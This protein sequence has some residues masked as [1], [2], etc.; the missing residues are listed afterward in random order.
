VIAWAAAILLAAR[1]GGAPPGSSLSPSPPTSALV[2]AE[3]RAEANRRPASFCSLDVC[4]P[5]LAIPG[6][7]AKVG[8]HAGRT[9]LA[10]A[11]LAS[12]DAEPISGVARSIALAGLRLDYLPP[13]MESGQRSSYGRVHLSVHWRLD[14]FGE[15]VWLAS[16]R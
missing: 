4:Q 6:Q 3:S 5:A 16:T 15:P 12:L 2:F 7:E 14:A 9:E 1:G 13:Q 11:M 10:L 8:G